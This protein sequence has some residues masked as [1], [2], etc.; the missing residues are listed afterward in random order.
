MSEEDMEEEFI[1]NLLKLES[2]IDKVLDK[3]FN[4]LLTHEKCPSGANFSGILAGSKMQ[5]RAEII[6][7]INK[8]G[9]HRYRNLD[10]EA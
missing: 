8:I 1:S 4:F 6:K 3:E 7:L 2:Y 9:G 10:N 5:A